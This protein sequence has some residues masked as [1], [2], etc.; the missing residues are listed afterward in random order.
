LGA[1]AISREREAGTLEFLMAHPISRTQ[2]LVEKYLFNLAALALPVILS[3]M[4]TWPAA[5]FY[6]EVINPWYLLL[7]AVYALLVMAILYSI[8]FCIGVFIDDQMK[9]ISFGIGIGLLMFALSV[10]RETRNFSIFGYFETDY[11][12]P[13]LTAGYVPFARM[14]GFA[15]VCF[16]LFAVSFWKFRKLNI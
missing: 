8:A 11:M 15:L 9:T 16:I 14:T 3:T 6:N 10:F 1:S 2:V 4:L 13:I 7:S 12:V 5:L